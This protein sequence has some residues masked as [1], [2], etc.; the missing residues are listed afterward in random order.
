MLGP[1]RAARHRVRFAERVHHASTPDGIVTIIGEEPRDRA[2]HQDDAA[3]AHRRRARRRLEERHASSRPISTT[4]KYG[5]PDRRRQHRRRRPTG[6]PMRQVGAAGAR[7]CSS[8][9]RRRRGACPQAELHDRVGPRASTPRRNRSLGYGELAAK[10]ATLPPPDLD[11][12]EAEGPE[13]LQDHRQAH[14]AASTTRRSSPASRCSAST[15]RCPGMLYAVLREVPGVRRQ[16]REREPRRDQGDAR[17]APRV[18]RRRRRRISTGLLPRRRDRRRQLVAG[19]DRARRSC[20]VTWDEGPTASQSSAGFAAKAAELVEAGRRAHRCAT[21]GDVDA[22]LS[23]AAKVVEGAYFVS[24]HLARAA[25][26]A[27]LHG[28]VQ[29]RQARD[30]GA[31]ADAG[32]AAAR[33]SRRRSA[34]SETDIT[35]HM[36][37]GGGGFGRRL[38]NDYMVEAAWIAKQVGVPVKLLWTREDDMQPRLLPSRRLPLPQ[39]RRRRGRQARRV[40]RITSSPS[41]RASKFAPQRADIGA[42]EFPARFVPNFALRRVDD[43]ARRADGR[44]ARAAAATRIAFVDPVVHRRAGARGRRRIRCS[45]ARLLTTRRCSPP[46]PDAA[47]GRRPGRGGP[48]DGFDAARMRGVLELVREKSGWGT[49]RRCRRARGMGVAFHFSHAATSP[50]S[51]R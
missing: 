44:A 48:G 43:A 7:R 12:G 31:D 47:P 35:L 42:D 51:P 50:R 21:D 33:S 9:P 19:A 34:S 18:R 41:A 32:S 22:A 8:P 2:G 14:A 5:A 23:G 11:D 24:V 10:A 16:G 27:E 28:A 25:R 39:G 4:A 20:K 46:P 15:S 17:R 13:G 26:A 30:L 3:D 40:A 6:T 38:T 37:R 1:R 49:R 36:M 45:S 29:G